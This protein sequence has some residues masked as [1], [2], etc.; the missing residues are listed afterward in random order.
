MYPGDEAIHANASA[1][2]LI[3]PG[4]REGNSIRRGVDASN[5]CPV[6]TKSRRI[7]AAVAGILFLSTFPGAQAADTETQFVPEMWAF[8]DLSDRARLFFLLNVNDNVT[9]SSRDET[10]GA[11]LDIALKP[12][13]RRSLRVEDWARKKYLWVRLGYR[14]NFG[15]GTRETG[16]IEANSRFALP[17]GI[18]VLSRLRT[19]LR[20]ETGGFSVRP[21]YRLGFERELPAGRLTVTPY[22]R[23]EVLYDSRPVTW[24]WRCQ[25]GAEFALNRHWRIEPYYARRQNQRAANINRIVFIVKTYW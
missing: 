15:G 7:R 8:V 16:V 25:V 10:I 14:R 17:R 11:N 18:W 24:D 5:G 21:R 2:T 1:A 9:Q 19:D 6:P 23:A 12:I 13:L 20:N 4:W 22:V 3:L